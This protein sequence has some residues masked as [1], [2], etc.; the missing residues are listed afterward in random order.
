MSSSYLQPIA[1][2]LGDDHLII[3]TNQRPPVGLEGW[4]EDDPCRY[5]NQSCR[6]KMFGALK[7]CR[8]QRE[9]SQAL[10][11][12]HEQKLAETK[13]IE[14]EKQQ[15]MTALQNNVTDTAAKQQT[16]STA[17]IAG[18]AVGGVAILGAAILIIAK[19]K[20]AKSQHA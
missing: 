19:K 8:R 12:A 14:Q 17:M 11:K 13:K 3:S 5:A 10:C 20:K 2:E 18:A 7:S 15:L 4:Q 9:K 1:I 6:G 16:A